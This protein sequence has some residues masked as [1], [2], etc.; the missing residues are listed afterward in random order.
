MEPAVLNNYQSVPE[1]IYFVKKLVWLMD[2]AFTFPLIRKRVGLDPI[3]GLVPGLGDFVA[4]S[5]S[6]F[7]IF[8]LIRYGATPKLVVK[9]FG[10]V[11]L[12]FV[13]G[14]IPVIGGVWDFF[15]KS[16]KKNLQLLIDYHEAQADQI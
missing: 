4:A 13:I 10:N 16:N 9:M 2:E 8:S 5:I 15:F 7:I 14:G 6:V 12:D 3:I 11:I 1:E